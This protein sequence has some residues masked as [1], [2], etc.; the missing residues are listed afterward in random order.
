[1]KGH[2]FDHRGDILTTFHYDELEDK[3]YLRNTQDVNPYLKQNA[4]ERDNQNARNN[5]GLQ[6]IASVPMNVIEEWRKE[7]GSDPLA[8]ENRGWLM[9]RLHSPEFAYLRTRTGR[10]L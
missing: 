5:D 4:I 8:R 7:L 2:L 1:V 6:K 3:S 10:F 9:K